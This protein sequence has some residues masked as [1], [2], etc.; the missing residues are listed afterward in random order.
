MIMNDEGTTPLISGW[1]TRA[2]CF[3]FHRDFWEY[4]T[5]GGAWKGRNFHHI[6]LC[7]KCDECWPEYLR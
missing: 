2:I 1:F 6:Q 5:Y 4:Q 3:L 7:T